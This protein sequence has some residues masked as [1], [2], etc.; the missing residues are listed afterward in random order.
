MLCPL[1]NVL[2]RMG[3]VCILSPSS[4]TVNHYITEEDDPYKNKWKEPFSLLAKTF[5]IYVA[6][7]TG[8]GY[9]VG[10][11][12]E[13]KKMI[14][15]S[16]VAC[17]DGSFQEAVCNEFAGNVLYVDIP[18]EQKTKYKGV[19]IGRRVKELGFDY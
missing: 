5:Q 9:I 13:G 3:A 17:P 16:L 18:V 7:A 2:A 15:C 19:Q 1:E 10:G 6:G 14:G 4:W 8:V 11:P 12:Y